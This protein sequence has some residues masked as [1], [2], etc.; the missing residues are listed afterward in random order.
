MPPPDGCWH[1]RRSGA[2]AEQRYG[3]PF[4]LIHRGDLQAALRAAVEA[5]ADISLH[6]ATKVEDFSVRDD[7]VTVI[8]SDSG[9]A[10]SRNMAPR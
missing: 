3:A 4:W 2:A 1:A 7:D 8:A 10:D 9:A 6:L 5:N